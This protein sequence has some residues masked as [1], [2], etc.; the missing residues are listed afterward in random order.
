MF[1][2]S[3]SELDRGLADQGDDVEASP[4]ARSAAD[5]ATPR[6]M[7]APIAPQPTSAPISIAAPPPPLA[8]QSAPTPSSVNLP[9]PPPWLPASAFAAI[10]AASEALSTA[11]ESSPPEPAPPPRLPA[12]T[13]APGSPRTLLDLFPP[14]VSR[15]STAPAPPVG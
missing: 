15:D 14:A 11:F 2:A 6:P 3:L 1:V 10:N 4:P 12:Q 5:R 7:P 9:E 8:A 13:G